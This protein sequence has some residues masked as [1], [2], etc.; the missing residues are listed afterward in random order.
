VDGIL[1]SPFWD[2]LTIVA[3]AIGL[4]AAMA[5]VIRYQRLSGCTWWRHRDGSPNLFGRF[6]MVRKIL[7]S[8]LFGLFLANRLIGP[9]A[10]REAVTS[11]ITLAVAIHTFVPYRLL[12]EAQ[13]A[14]PKE[15]VT[16][17]V[18]R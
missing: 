18:R 3:C 17:D 2:K 7:L 5:F 16:D 15:E 11:L 10:A 9:W 4:I 12:T 14:Q 6:L 8:A 13:K 1:A